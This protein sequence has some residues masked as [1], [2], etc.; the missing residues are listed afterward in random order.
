[1]SQGTPPSTIIQK[2]TTRDICIYI[3]ILPWN[4]TMKI[5]AYLSLGFNTLL[6]ILIP[7]ISTVH[8]IK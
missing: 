2:A 7:D 1:M 5:R 8:N 3:S 4:K 6:F